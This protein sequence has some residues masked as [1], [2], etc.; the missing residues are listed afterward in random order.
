MEQLFRVRDVPPDIF[1]FLAA[2][3]F[4]GRDDFAAPFELIQKI[5]AP[6]ERSFAA[7]EGCEI[8]ALHGLRRLESG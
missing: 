3:T 5:V 2:N 7:Q 8:M 1:P 6:E 4:G